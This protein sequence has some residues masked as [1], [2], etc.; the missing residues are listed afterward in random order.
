MKLSPRASSQIKDAASSFA[1]SV[2]NIVAR[3]TVAGLAG[4]LHQRIDEL[5]GTTSRRGG[6]GPAAAAAPRAP[7]AGRRGRSANA[8]Y[9]RLLSRLV[10]VIKEN[11][12]KADPGAVSK[13][14]RLSP[15]QR[16]RLVEAA[17]AKGLVKTSGVRR[18]TKYLL[19]K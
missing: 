6:R 15:F 19:K 4:E 18:S 10:G 11:G 1:L 14:L 13:A 9:D 2:A 3:D 12:G 16:R 17:V 5:T 7:R 8:N